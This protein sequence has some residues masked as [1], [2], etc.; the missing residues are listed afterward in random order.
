MHPR[1]RIRRIGGAETRE[2]PCRR[3]PLRRGGRKGR[4]APPRAGP[5]RSPREAPPEVRRRQGGG[6]EDCTA[7]NVGLSS[8]EAGPR[9]V[10]EDPHPRVDHGIKVS[11]REKQVAE[12]GHMDTDGVGIK[13]WETNVD[14]YAD[15][16][17]GKGGS[18]V[19]DPLRL[20]TRSEAPPRSPPHPAHSRQKPP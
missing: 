18:G 6:E 5:E 4:K 15:H 8:P 2:L 7:G 12:H 9:H 20:G 14:G 11:R 10:R 13:L 3:T 16:A 19:S 1:R 17:K